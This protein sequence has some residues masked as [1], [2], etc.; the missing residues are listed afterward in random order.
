MSKLP[1]KIHNQQINNREDYLKLFLNAKIKKRFSYQQLGDKLG[2][3]KVWIAAALHGKATMDE[4]EVKLLCSVLDLECGDDMIQVLSQ[5]PFRKPPEGF[6]IVAADPTIYR[7]Y[8]FVNVYG[9]ALKA[10]IHEEC[11]DGIMSAIGL[12]VNFDVQKR[13]DGEHIVII[14]DGKFLPYKKW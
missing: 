12:Q 13:E 6:N 5:P 1:S 7:L 14:L 3:D 2:R 4:E 10:L 11:G 9:E 8:E